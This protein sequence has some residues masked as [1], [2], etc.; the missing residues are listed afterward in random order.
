MCCHGFAINL[1]NP[2]CTNNDMTVPFN[3]FTSGLIIILFI[4]IGKIKT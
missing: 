4:F 3:L 1:I 2:Y